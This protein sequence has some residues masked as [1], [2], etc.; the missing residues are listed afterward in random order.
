MSVDSDSRKKESKKESRKGNA[1]HSTFI[2]RQNW[3]L[4]V[5]RLGKS[6]KE[7]ND[8]FGLDRLNQDGER[9]HEAINQ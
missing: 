9:V 8:M 4:L 6:G 5:W 1:R 2:C 7:S 3:R